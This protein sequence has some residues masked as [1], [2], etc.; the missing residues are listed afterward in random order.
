VDR[1]VG[2]DEGP[3]LVGDVAGVMVSSH[4]PIIRTA[5]LTGQTLNIHDERNFTVL[6]AMPSTLTCPSDSNRTI[7]EAL[8]SSNYAGNCG[9]NLAKGEGVFVMKG[10][11]PRDITDGFSSTV[12]TSEWIVG[13]GGYESSNRY[14]SVYSIENRGVTLPEF[15]S[16]CAGMNPDR[17]NPAL[18]GIKGQYWICGGMGATQYNHIMTPN[19]LSCNGAFSAITSGSF[20]PGG[21]NVLALDGSVHFVK[22]SINPFVWTALG[23]RSA[24]ESTNNPFGL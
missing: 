8:W 22:D 2:L 9:R 14:G 17:A 3:L 24:G 21:A 18:P 19:K 12:A 6:A 5:T 7:P 15:A 10:L 16:I 1:D 13:S 23:T 20:H 4:A 11:N